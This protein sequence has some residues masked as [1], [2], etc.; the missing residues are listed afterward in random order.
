MKTVKTI[1]INYTNILADFGFFYFLLII[2][3]PAFLIYADK[4]LLFGSLEA[5]LEQKSLKPILMKSKLSFL[6]IT[7]YNKFRVIKK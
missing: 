1:L 4:Y 3:K 7:A 2:Y 5:A 6:L